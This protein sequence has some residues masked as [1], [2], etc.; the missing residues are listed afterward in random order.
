[1]EQTCTVEGHSNNG[2]LYYAV[3]KK[4][5]QDS[6]DS[7]LEAKKE[8]LNRMSQHFREVADR[9][10]DNKTLRAIATTL[11]KNADIMADIYSLIQTLTIEIGNAKKENKEL[12]E[13]IAQKK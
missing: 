10:Y 2:F 1:M 8:Y 5:M 3:A 7:S 9:Q 13:A 6:S 11:S 12:R 4:Q